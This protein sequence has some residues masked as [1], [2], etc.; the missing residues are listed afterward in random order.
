MKQQETPGDLPKLSAPAHRALASV[1]VATLKDL[2]QHTQ[3]EIAKLHGMGPS[4][5]KALKAALAE[6]GLA[7]KS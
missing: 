1:H 6:K 5:I 2:S 3:A 7:F 4:G